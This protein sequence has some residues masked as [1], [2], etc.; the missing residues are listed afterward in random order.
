MAVLDGIK[1]RVVFKYFEEICAIPHGSR[2]TKA[3]SDYLEE[4]A[5]AYELD[6]VRDEKGNLIIRKDGREYNAQ[7]ATIQ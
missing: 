3:I 5:K 2:N 4:F 6:Y 7:G 1:P